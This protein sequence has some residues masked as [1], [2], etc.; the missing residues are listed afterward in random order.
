[1][2]PQEEINVIKVCWNRSVA[3]RALAHYYNV[4]L[5]EILDILE[6]PHDLKKMERI[7]REKNFYDHGHDDALEVRMQ[8]YGLYLDDGDFEKYQKY[9]YMSHWNPE[10]WIM[11]F[12][13]NRM[14]PSTLPSI[15]RRRL[16][17]L[18]RFEKYQAEKWAEY[19]DRAKEIN[20]LLS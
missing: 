18:M 1:M 3:P 2:I 20:K 6:L 7:H 16:W 9:C 4:P 15:E 13:V 11:K 10:F 5:D 12:W 8:H 14:K 17:I 19:E